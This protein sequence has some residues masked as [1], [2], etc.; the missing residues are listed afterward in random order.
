M[1][2]WYAGN[3]HSRNI[4]I[5]QRKHFDLAESEGLRKMLKCAV[6]QYAD[7]VIGGSQMR[8]KMRAREAV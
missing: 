2:R 4:V 3:L 1:Y 8:W 5:E 6:V 7:V